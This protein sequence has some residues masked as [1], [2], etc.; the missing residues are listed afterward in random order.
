MMEKSSS[1]KK[2]VLI[3]KFENSR[4]EEFAFIIRLFIKQDLFAEQTLIRSIC[5]FD[6]FLWN[7]KFSNVREHG[8]AGT[9]G[10]G[11]AVK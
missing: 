3:K 1:S 4:P 9:N 7:V 5:R 8:S 10:S 11:L 6:G 2:S